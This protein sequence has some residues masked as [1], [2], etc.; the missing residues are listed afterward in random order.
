MPAG[1]PAGVLSGGQQKLLEIV[2]Q[3]EQSA[4][5]PNPMQELQTAAMQ[6]DVENKQANTMLTVAKAQTEQVRPIE[7]GLRA[8]GA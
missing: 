5:Q 1:E 7:L 8:G 3:M 6:A 4:S 2:D